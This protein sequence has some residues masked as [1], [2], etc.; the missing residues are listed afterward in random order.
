MFGGDR[1][2]GR[3]EAEMMNPYQT[4]SSPNT[5]CSS[6]FSLAHLATWEQERRKMRSGRRDG[7]RKTR[8]GDGVEEER[9]IVL[10][11]KLIFEYISKKP[12]ITFC[13]KRCIDIV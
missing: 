12:P 1:N 3:A 13:P 6:S 5:G 4:C 10:F 7:E 8:E 11:N 9:K 2:I